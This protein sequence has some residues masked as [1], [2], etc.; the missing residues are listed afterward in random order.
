MLIHSWT[1]VGAYACSL[2][3][4]VSLIFNETTCGRLRTGLIK[5][6]CYV[7]V[8]RMPDDTREMYLVIFLRMTVYGS[9]TV[10]LTRNR[11]G[12]L[13]ERIYIDGI[14]VSR[15][16]GLAP[17]RPIIILYYGRSTAENG[18]TKLIVL[19]Q[20]VHTFFMS[21]FMHWY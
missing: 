5:E 2:D 20:I 4:L 18:R 13:Q 1:R 21:N 11:V 10:S 6:R 9:F 19:R 17:A 16:G 7:C 14:P 15:L 3:A 12:R 8:L